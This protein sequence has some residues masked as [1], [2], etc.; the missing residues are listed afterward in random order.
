VQDAGIVEQAWLTL[1]ELQRE[2]KVR[3][4]GVSNFDVPLMDLCDARRPIESVQMP[5][6]LLSR[7]ACRDRLPWTAER[8]VPALAY[9]PLES[10]LLSGGFG[11]QRLASLPEGDR[12]RERAQFQGPRLDRTLRLLERLEPI[13]ARLGATLA[14]LAIAWTLAWPGVGGAIVGARAAA[15][16][17]GWIGAAKLVLDNSTLTEIATA[18]I[19][20]EAGQGPVSPHPGA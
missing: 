20:S 19:E 12:R 8:D 7:A 4:T 16:V 10:G 13:A 6:S 11:R 2:G 1:A 9:S 14:E 5:L 15:Q 18:L 3:S 17:D